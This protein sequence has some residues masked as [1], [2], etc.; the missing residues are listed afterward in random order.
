[1]PEIFTDF[2]VPLKIQDYVI[3]DPD[4]SS[5]LATEF[6]PPVTNLARL[7]SLKPNTLQ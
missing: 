5:A 7:P 4:H 3:S 1:M 2:D 6:A